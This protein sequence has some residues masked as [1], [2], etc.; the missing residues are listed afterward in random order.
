VEW[1]NTVVQGV[2][3][4]GLYSLF[5]IGLSLA[6][7]VMRLVNIA[8][9]DFIVLAAYLGLAVVA[10]ADVHPFVALPAV[11]VMMFALGYLLQRGVLNLTLGP[12]ILPP[13]LVT[14]GLSIIIQNVLLEVFSADSKALKIGD[15]ETA[16]V[17]LGEQLAVGW[18]P[19][20]IFAVALAMTAGLELVFARTPLGMAFRATSDDQQIAQLMGIR[21]RHVYGIAMGLS[22][23]LMAVGGV[24]LGIKTT[25]T[26]DLGPGYLLYSFEAVVIGGLGSFWGSFAG[27]VILGV[28]QG[29][30]AKID[31]GYRE[32]AGHLVFLA[33]L[34]FKPTG[35]FARTR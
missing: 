2:L 26:P 27:S 18:F 19:L 22:F 30:G 35:L 3:L 5:A 17:H 9:G 24:F 7:G 23:S 16:S 15:L 29:I 12:D 10:A 14:F 11:V 8:H 4:G 31:P 34:L 6:Y 20:I 21:N 33:V 32:L 1:I 13:L 28:A 25:F